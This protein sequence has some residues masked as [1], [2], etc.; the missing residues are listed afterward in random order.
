MN[1]NL[2]LAEILKDCPKERELY[3]PIFGVV[4]FE[5][6][7]DTGLGLALIEV[8]T[9]DNSTELF[10]SN[11]KYNSHYSDSECTL[12]PSKENKDWSKFQMLFKD[13]DV[14]YIQANYEYIAIYK[15][16]SDEYL[17]DHAVIS[18][19]R[20]QCDFT[21]LSHKDHIEKMRFAT[22]EEKQKL[23]D[24]IKANGYKW[25]NETKTLEELIEPKFKV[26][27]KIRHKTHIRQGNAVTEIKDTHYILDDELA[28]PFTSQD[29][30]EL[31]PSKF[32]ISTLKPF[33]KVLIRDT[34]YSKWKLSFWGFYDIDND[35]PYE[36]C[37][38]MFAQCIPYEGNQHLLG[39]TDDCDE[40]FKTWE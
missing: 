1:E 8:S 14:V 13:G 12:F 33:D 23:F 29:E 16:L 19:N 18:D 10:Y 38:G 21:P 25:N 4:Y 9:E 30:Y 22:E 15:E 28:H 11:G 37:G 3:S 24:A 20:F 7:K 26:G 32:D 17:Y 27:D 35:Y 5:G 36:C 39:T 40:Y 31:A 34:N 2:N 6:V